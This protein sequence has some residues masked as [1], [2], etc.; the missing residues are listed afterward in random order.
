MFRGGAK[1]HETGQIAASGP[2]ANIIIALITLFLYTS[3][4]YESQIGKILGFVCLINSFIATFNLLPLGPL[5]G[6][7]IINWNATIWIIMLITSV[8]I[9]V[10]LMIISP[11]VL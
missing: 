1:T 6:I 9:T 5:D 11:I 10:F 4:F 7:K 2:L 3:V 8:L